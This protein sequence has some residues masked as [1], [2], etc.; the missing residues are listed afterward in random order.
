[1]L[2]DMEEKGSDDTLFSIVVLM[3]RGSGAE[4][5]LEYLM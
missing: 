4:A 1:M 5:Q 3:I 2:V